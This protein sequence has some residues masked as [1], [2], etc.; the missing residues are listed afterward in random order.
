MH[1]RALTLNQYQPFYMWPLRQSARG[2]SIEVNPTYLP[3]AI[4]RTT[5]LSF[6]SPPRNPPNP[7]NP[8]SDNGE[9][10]HHVVLQFMQPY[11]QTFQI[12]VGVDLQK[13]I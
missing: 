1:I 9:E 3:E 10:H 7:E 4:P 2:M 12:E 5:L 11:E 13:R 6:F 8:L